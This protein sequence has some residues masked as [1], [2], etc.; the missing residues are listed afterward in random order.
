LI[1]VNVGNLHN[2][3]HSKGLTP[4]TALADDLPNSISPQF[5]LM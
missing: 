5:G 2:T 3:S 4:L 1:Q